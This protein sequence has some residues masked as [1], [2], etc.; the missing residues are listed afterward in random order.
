MPEESV[1]ET[2]FE[3]DRDESQG[4]GKQRQY[5][6]RARRKQAKINGH[7]HQ[8]ECTVDD[9]PDSEDQR[10]LDGLLDFVVDR[11]DYSR[12]RLTAERIS[13]T[14]VNAAAAMLTYRDTKKGRGINTNV[15]TWRPAG[16]LIPRIV[17][18]AL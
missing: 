13:M 3:D 10:V 7:Q 5:A 11:G 8:A 17:Q 15:T 12:F 9:A 1:I 2:E 16:T 6:E 4:D 18:L 14:E